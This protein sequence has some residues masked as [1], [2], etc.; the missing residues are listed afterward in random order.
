MESVKQPPLFIVYTSVSHGLLKAEMNITN[1]VLM[2]E[3][4][5]V[6][7]N[8]IIVGRNKSYVTEDMLPVSSAILFLVIKS[9]IGLV[10][11]FFQRT[12]GIPLVTN[13][14]PLLVACFSIPM[15]V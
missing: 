2:H 13:C 10:N 12:V 5:A 11:L 4:R 3:N 14:V 8:D 15:V 9:T 1:N 7:Y 6:R